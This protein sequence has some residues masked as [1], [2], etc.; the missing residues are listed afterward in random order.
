MQWK[1]PNN[2]RDFVTI[3]P[4]DAPEK[5]YEAYE[6]T[7]KGSP[8]ELSAPDKAGEYEV[9]Y[10][11]AQNY[12]TLGTAKV[13]VTAISATLQGPAEAVAGSTFPVSWKGPNNAHDY[14]TIVPKGARE[15]DERQLG[16]TRLAA[17]PSEAARAAR[18]RVT[19]SCAMQPGNPH[20][21]CA[22]GRAHHAREAGAR[23]RC[24]H[25]VRARR[26]PRVRWRSFSTRRAACSSASASSAASTSRSR[27]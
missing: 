19:T 5:R 1:G 15:G 23:P 13:T 10:L 21:A 18:C 9:R 22:R 17:I 27:R 14:I 24:R 25:G 20:H 3:V 7:S 6:Y 26:R 4:A 12:L 16:G 2:P 8:L 11:T